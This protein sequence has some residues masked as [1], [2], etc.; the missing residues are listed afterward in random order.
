[1]FY[2]M[3]KYKVKKL[4]KE[5]LRESEGKV[6]TEELF[7]R[8]TRLVKMFIG[9]MKSNIKYMKKYEEDTALYEHIR[10]ELDTVEKTLVWIEECFKKHQEECLL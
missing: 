7:L 1:M 4:S 2:I 8:D 9:Y 5:Q 6:R 10:N 3:R